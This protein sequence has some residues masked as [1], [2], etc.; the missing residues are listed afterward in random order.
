M[1]LTQKK[2]QAKESFKHTLLTC[3]ITKRTLQ[4]YGNFFA[5]FARRA[6]THTHTKLLLEEKA[7]NSERKQH[8]DITDLL[9]LQKV[10]FSV[11]YDIL[12]FQVFFFGAFW[13]MFFFIR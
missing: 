3:V 12:L 10:R 13:W 5:S 2:Q 8:N 1:Y 7:K 9:L 11:F 6:Y 4:W